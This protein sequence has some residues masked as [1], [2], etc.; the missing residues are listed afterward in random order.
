MIV[1]WYAENDYDF[2][3]LSD[4]NI[5]AVSD[6]WYDLEAI[7][8]R[9]RAIGRSAMDK[10]QAKYG[11]KKGWIETRS[12]GEKT[13]VRL[14][15]IDEYRELFEK[16]GEFLV[17]Q[18]EENLQHLR[19]RQTGSHQCGQSARQRTPLSPLKRKPDC[20]SPKSSVKISRPLPNAKRRPENRS[21]PT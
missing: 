11:D 16:P 4:H 7:A 9:Q 20:Q 21:W 10:Y 17:V 6:K 1:G 13:E 2:I 19:R 15:R 5:L 8:K 12:K 14:K 3:A 18:A